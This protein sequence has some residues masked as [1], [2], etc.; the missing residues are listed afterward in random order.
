[1]SD[2]LHG[3][4]FP[5][6]GLIF[7]FLA[8]FLSLYPWAG[9]S[10]G[11]L[12]LLWP[13]L[14]FI[15]IGLA[16]LLCPAAG[17]RWLCKDPR[18]GQIN[19]ATAVIFL[20]F[21]MLSWLIWLV[22]HLIKCESP[23]D[24]V[25]EDFYVGRYC[26]RYPA[27]FPDDAANVVDLTAEFPARCDVIRGRNYLCLPSLDREMPPAHDLADFARQVEALEGPTYV[28]CAN[29]HGRSALVVAMVMIMRG[30]APTI[31]GEERRARRAWE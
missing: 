20:P 12:V 3:V 25:Y 26:M 22:K 5:L 21:L 8:F 27:Q 10:F 17:A 4:G 11:H 9:Q 24:R 13:A 1:M 16:H 28:H 30:A 14:A 31:E 23:Y 15:S 2:R 18:T 29:G 7:A 19:V 6:L